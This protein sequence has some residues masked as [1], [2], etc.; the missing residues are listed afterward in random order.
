MERD[1]EVDQ[2]GFDLG[3][4]ADRRTVAA[5]L[6]YGLVGMAAI[7]LGLVQLFSEFGLGTAVITKKDMSEDQ[8]SQLNTVSLL[9]ALGGLAFS[10]ALAIPHWQVFSGA[11]ATYGYNRD[12]H[13]IR[14]FCVF[15]CSQCTAAERKCTSRFWLLL[16][17]Y[18]AWHRRFRL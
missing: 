12:E 3:D 16:K 7:Y 8:V 11:E 4:D 9:F 1:G 13:G 10:V 5:A 6:R 15:S 14:N 18:R 17:G 2:S